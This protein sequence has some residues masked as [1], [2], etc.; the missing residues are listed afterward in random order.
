MVSDKLFLHPANVRVLAS[1][2][3]LGC[4]RN[5]ESQGREG[6][7]IH[8]WR[9]RQFL[10]SLLRCL[11]LVF[12]GIASSEFRA[13]TGPF[14]N[15][16]RQRGLVA[17]LTF[18]VYLCGYRAASD[19]RNFCDLHVFVLNTSALISQDRTAQLKGCGVHQLQGVRLSALWT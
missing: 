7:H 2:L 9:W 11:R 12:I 15:K 8:Q 19:G 18:P 5:S 3:G 16:T 6:Y 13:G 17:S 1:W 14:L 4:F 10:K